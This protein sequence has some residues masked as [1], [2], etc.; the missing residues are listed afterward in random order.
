M[1]SLR[2][3]LFFILVAA[4][5]LIW[6]SAGAWIYI[7][8][9]SELEH[10]LDTRLQEAAKMVHSLVDAHT[11]PA[12]VDALNAA[13][14]AEV[15]GYERQLSCQIWSLDGQLVARS[16]GAPAARLAENVDGYSDRIVDGEPW[17]VYTIQDPVKRVRVM[18][19]DR[20][21][22][23]HKLVNDLIV[24]LLA[25][26]LLVL[27]LFGLLTWASLGRGLRPLRSMAT[28]L[29][30][31]DAEDMRPLDASRLPAEV[32]PLAHALNALFDKVE[33]ARRHEREITAFAAHELRTPLAG[34]KTQA[35]V[36]RAAADPAVRDRA[37]S[38]ILVSVDR[39]TRLVRQLL[40]L[41]R[42]EA[43]TASPREG[44]HKASDL[45]TEIVATA[46][47]L[48]ANVR[49]EIDPELAGVALPGARDTWMLALRNV[50]ENAI[51]H[52]PEGGL[53][54]WCAT[55][56]GRGVM[57]VDQGPGIPEEE[58]ALVTQRFYR[59]R[60]KSTSGTGLGLTIVAIA[61]R[62]LGV[63]LVLSNRQDR[64]GLQAAFVLPRS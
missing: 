61:A 32:Q 48:A 38:Q 52:M 43:E 30:G 22:L 46:P 51:H 19:G 28:E 53:V 49:V 18:V 20:I 63:E 3:R 2:R 9:R 17:R 54:R 29:Q 24:G 59:G 36:A 58:L 62:R 23:R 64:S 1:T 31:R 42:L 57:A 26:A 35:Q 8:S 6:L 34:L 50:H 12:S 41:T 5:G 37:L 44:A 14:P 10:V 27:P 13:L 21:G 4:T 45:L 55:P 40:V 56:D 11:M 60:H 39:T 47:P 25:P 7:G 15:Q 33:A 16:S